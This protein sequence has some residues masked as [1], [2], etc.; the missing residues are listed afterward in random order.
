[1]QVRDRPS[2]GL[3]PNNPAGLLPNKAKVILASSTSHFRLNKRA[4]DKKGPMTSPWNIFVLEKTCGS[5]VL[6]GCRTQKWNKV[7]VSIQP[8]ISLLYKFHYKSLKSSSKTFPAPF[9][10]SEPFRR[11]PSSAG[12]TPA[13]APQDLIQ[14]QIHT[15][16][17]TTAPNEEGSCPRLT[18]SSQ[19]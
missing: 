7:L 18:S 4:W 17:P 11:V 6:L 1:M 15:A 2:L 16:L 13:N 10:A 19:G 3:S 14:G 8:L 5:V 12:G 9:G